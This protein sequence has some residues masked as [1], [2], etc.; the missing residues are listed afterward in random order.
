MFTLFFRDKAPENLIEVNQCD[1]D[2]F[3]RFFKFMLDN[4]ILLPP[5]QYE[6][7]FLS[8]KHTKE[9]LELYYKLLEEFLKIEGLKE[10]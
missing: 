9:D 1:F 5:S 3:S 8:V 4:G 10:A 7:N 6:A 2:M